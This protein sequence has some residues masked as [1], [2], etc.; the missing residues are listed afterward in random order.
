MNQDIIKEV[1]AVLDQ[2]FVD[3]Q[4]AWVRKFQGTHVVTFSS[5]G[6]CNTFNIVD[7]NEMFFVNSTASYFNYKESYKSVFIASVAGLQKNAPKTP[8]FTDKNDFGLHGFIFDVEL[9]T[10]VI[11]SPYEIPDK[12]HRSFVL[13]ENEISRLTIEPMIR[14][15][16]ETLLD[17]DADKYEC[18]I[19]YSK[20]L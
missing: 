7:Q 14:I 6:W 19:I 2:I 12:R 20:F 8:L 13:A 17:Q 11:H 10:V 15:T 9:V 5:Y 16:D 4:I 3:F 1:S 18:P